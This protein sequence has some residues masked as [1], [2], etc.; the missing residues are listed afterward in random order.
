MKTS[1]LSLDGKELKKI[2]LPNQFSEEIRADLIKRAVLNLQ[3]NRRVAYGAK[4]RAGKRASATISKRRKSY[5]T[6]YGH[7]ISRVP[8][9]ILTRRG[10]RFYWV[11]AVAPGTVGGRKAHP[12]KPEKSWEQKINNKERKKAI[13]SAM[14]ATMVPELVKKRN[15]IL[16]KI[17]P[18]IMENKIE[19]VDKTSKIKIILNNIDLKKELTRV[20]IKKIRAGKGKTRTKTFKLKKGPLVIVSKDCKLSKSAKNILGVDVC[21][22]KNLNAELLAPGANPGR[23]T[24]WSEAAI[25]RIAKEKLFV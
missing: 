21:L 13:R 8:R 2:D 9:K 18:L 20:S 11:G 23:L 24:I 22:V 17:Y 19:D 5:K 10:T 6:A 15:H 16:P 14:S 12:P 4:E 3:T 25:E 7:G 1:V